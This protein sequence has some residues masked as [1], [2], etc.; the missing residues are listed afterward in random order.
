[1][2]RITNREC[3]AVYDRAVGPSLEADSPAIDLPRLANLRTILETPFISPS[4]QAPA[5]GAAPIS[6]A[7]LSVSSGASLEGVWGRKGE[8]A[9]FMYP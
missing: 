4:S 2:S 6:V 5:R 1:M 9:A 8:R 3:V 7:R